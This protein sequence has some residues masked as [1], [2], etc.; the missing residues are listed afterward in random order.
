VIAGSASGYLKQGVSVKL[1]D[2]NLG[3]GNS[4]VGCTP[5]GGEVTFGT[6]SQ[7]GNVPLNKLYV[8]LMNAVGA[9]DENGQPIQSFGTWDSNSGPGITNPGELT[10]LRAG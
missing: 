3:T 6:G 1:A 5:D 2:G 9:T 4:E 10:A 7:G 8:T